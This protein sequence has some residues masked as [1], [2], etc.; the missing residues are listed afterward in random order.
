MPGK[1]KKKYYAVKIGRTPGI[2][3]EWNEV[4]A[5]VTG[6]AG[7]VFKSFKLKR[8]AT[9]FLKAKERTAEVEMQATANKFK[10]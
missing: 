5:Q 6:F 9:K 3:T 1:N 8:D 10:T 2:Y 7:A 4:E